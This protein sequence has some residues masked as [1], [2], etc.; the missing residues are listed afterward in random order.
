M[1]NGAVGNNEQI[2]TNAAAAVARPAKA[3]VVFFVCFA[4][5]Y[6]RLIKLARERRMRLMRELHNVEQLSFAVP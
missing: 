4:K 5:R 1:Q 6:E 2:A 3:I